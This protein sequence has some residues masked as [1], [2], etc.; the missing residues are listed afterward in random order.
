MA[1][2]KSDQYEIPEEEKP[3]QNHEESNVEETTDYDKPRRKLQTRDYGKLI[4]EWHK[5][6]FS[7]RQGISDNTNIWKFI[8]NAKEE[9]KQILKE[10]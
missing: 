8:F 6:W 5:K 10:D 3:S 2:K 1:R 7:N 4:D 9:L